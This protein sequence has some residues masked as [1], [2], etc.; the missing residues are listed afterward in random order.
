MTPLP[1][2]ILNHERFITTIGLVIFILSTFTIATGL[3]VIFNGAYEDGHYT[4]NVST[5]AFLLN[6]YAFSMIVVAVAAIHGLF[7]E[8]GMFGRLG[9]VKS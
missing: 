4:F 6:A 1:T 8:I 3:V 5:V 2:I 9:G 7:D